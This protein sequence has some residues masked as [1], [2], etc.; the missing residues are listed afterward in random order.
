MTLPAGFLVGHATD[1]RA[2]T[3]CTVVL[4]PPGTV[5]AAEIRGGGPGTRE[6]DLLG[7]S[8]AARDVQALA[9][10]GGSAFGLAAADGVVRWLEAAGRGYRT[11]L[12]H[13]V[14]LV[15]AAVVFDLPLGNPA[16]RPEAVHGVAACEAATLDPARG[17]V[18]AGTGC[19]VG[20]LLGP[21][22]WTKGGVGLATEEVHGCRVT[23]LAVVNAFGDVLAEDGS[24]LAGPWREGGY[25][26]TADLLR[27]GDVPGL[28]TREAT[29]LVA[30]MT[31]A[32]LTK[33]DAW[34]LARAANTGV[35]RAVDPAATAVDG[36]AAYVLATGDVAAD[37][38]VLSAVVP[39]VVA[40][41]IRDGVRSATSLYGC[42]S[43]AERARA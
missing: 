25:V 12:G 14:P 13:L 38:F 9:F 3:G 6:S 33:T 16:V 26:R 21:A 17:T 37:P 43:A 22:G 1:L 34:L 27:S 18:G 39:G 20:K 24:V 10:C 28:G 19:A 29:T 2:A 7:P 11:R 15:P 40:A 23:A 30:L 42:P 35:A 32:T 41:A 36:D 8:S 5:A 31:D 4:A